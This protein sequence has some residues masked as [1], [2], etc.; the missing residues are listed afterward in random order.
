M[1]QVVANTGLLL[2]F[3]PPTIITLGCHPHVLYR[4]HLVKVIRETLVV[5][6]HIID[7]VV[8]LFPR[9]RG[10]AHGLASRIGVRRL[11]SNCSASRTLAG[12]LRR[13]LEQQELI[14]HSLAKRP[15]IRQVLR[16][17]LLAPQRLV[18]LGRLYLLAVPLQAL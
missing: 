8:A 11:V 9:N 15:L 10:T 1:R 13:P 14:L 18:A 5:Q 2:S 7:I 17:L 3:G 12:G 6:I 4:C 16:K